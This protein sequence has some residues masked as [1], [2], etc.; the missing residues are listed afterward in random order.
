M[1]NA[2]P[3]IPGFR[4][5]SQAGIQLGDGRERSPSPEAQAGGSKSAELTPAATASK[6]RRAQSVAVQPRE[7]GTKRP[8]PHQ[9]QKHQELVPQGSVPNG[10]YLGELPSLQFSCPSCGVVLTITE[11][12]SYNGKPGPCPHCSSVVLPPRVVSPFSMASTRQP[13]QPTQEEAPRHYSGFS[14]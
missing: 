10:L 2:A 7:P 5:L 9:Q 13:V 11:P 8:L 6:V 1:D 4:S 14:L 12:S 3:A